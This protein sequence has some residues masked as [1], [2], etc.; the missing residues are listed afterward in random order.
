MDYKQFFEV[1]AKVY[2][3]GIKGTGMCALAELL[4]H[5][6][7]LVWGSDTSDTF[8]TDE[9]L[10]SLGIPYYEGFAESH[11]A[12]SPDEKQKPD[13][14]IYSAAYSPDNN[15]EMAYALGAALPMLKYTDALGVFSSNFDS[16]GIA[17]VHGK[18]TTT[19]LAGTLIHSLNLPAQI[20]AGSG[21]AAFGGT[22]T[23]SLG[24]KYFVAET[25]EY[26]NHFLSFHPNRIILTSV[27]WDHQDFFPS[28]E[29]IRDSFVAYIKLLPQGG[30]LIYCFDDDGAREVV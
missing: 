30:C 20:L 11:L 23:L 5:S 27:E 25:C 6:G 12:N 18:T 14:V 3:I 29:S 15:C 4:F 7:V 24:Q 22:S 1:D 2:M 28:Y 8:Y 26:R 16:S 17:G 13:L 9:I 10:L 19:A 21:V